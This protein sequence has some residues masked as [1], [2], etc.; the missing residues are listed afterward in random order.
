MALFYLLLIV[1]IGWLLFRHGKGEGI[2][3]RIT[4][5]TEKEKYFNWLREIFV[6]KT[7][8]EMLFIGAV[9]GAA[10][11]FR[12]NKEKI[13]EYVGRIEKIYSDILSQLIQ[14]QPQVK[15]LLKLRQEANLGDYLEEALATPESYIAELIESNQTWIKGIK[16]AAERGD[17]SA[18]INFLSEME[19]S[20]RTSKPIFERWLNWF[21]KER[22]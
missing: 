18:I 6:F 17:S 10:G 2:K 21:E 7:D 14:R 4:G 20:I 19:R 22:Y 11:F 5:E 16:M 13:L 3:K 1:F 12:P 15:Q 8:Q 9:N